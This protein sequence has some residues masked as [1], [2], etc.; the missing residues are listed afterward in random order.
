MEFKSLKYP[1][2]A[3]PDN[4]FCEVSS[5]S[6]CFR[7]EDVYVIVDRCMDTGQLIDHKSSP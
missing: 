3:S 1:E 6:I 2:S 7:E 4:S 5:K